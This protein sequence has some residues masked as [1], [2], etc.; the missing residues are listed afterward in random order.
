MKQSVIYHHLLSKHLNITLQ[1]YVYFLYNGRW[2][3]NIL[4][5]NEQVYLILY[6]I[7]CICSYCQS[8]RLKDM[9][10]EWQEKGSRLF[11]WPWAPIKGHFRLD[12]GQCSCFTYG[13]A[14]TG[15][16][17]LFLQLWYHQIRLSVKKYVR[18]CILGWLIKP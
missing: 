2:K 5:F 3:Q 13:K 10:H 7:T 1:K 17:R 18:V 11:R 12:K 4:E 8:T 6:L 15:G 14:Q 9:C 16:K